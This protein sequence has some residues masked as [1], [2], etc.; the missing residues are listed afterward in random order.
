MDKQLIHDAILHTVAVMAVK[1]LQREMQN[2]PE[3]QALLDIGERL[4]LN[5]TPGMAD[6]W[7]PVEQALS[8]YGSYHVQRVFELE[9]L[10]N[11]I[12]GTAN[13]DFDLFISKI[14]DWAVEDVQRIIRRIITD[15]MS[16][17]SRVDGQVLV[18]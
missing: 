9:H 17:R 2:S 18:S 11:E 5:P 14:P 7:Q 1:Q 16:E 8:L 15:L 6:Q 3:V 10:L 13:P 4:R 12:R